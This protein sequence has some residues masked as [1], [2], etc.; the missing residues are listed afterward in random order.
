MSEREIRPWDAPVVSALDEV[1]K[2]PG[3]EPDRVGWDHFRFYG[4]DPNPMD[5]VSIYAYPPTSGRS[6]F[7]RF[8]VSAQGFTVTDPERLELTPSGMAQAFDVPTA[9]AEQAA[10]TLGAALMDALAEFNAAHF[11]RGASH[12]EERAAVDLDESYVP[13]PPGQHDRGHVPAAP[14]PV[15]GGPVPPR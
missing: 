5:S 4:V 15:R 11:Q 14:G 2:L 13:S 10:A 1:E 12:G 3:F 8:G 7:V 6:K 9:S